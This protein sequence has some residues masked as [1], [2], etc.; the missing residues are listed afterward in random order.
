MLEM[1]NSAPESEYYSDS[2]QESQNTDNQRGVQGAELS[3]FTVPSTL[4]VCFS[5]RCP[6]AHI[7]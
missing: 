2:F 1:H 7:T 6:S 5:V 4:P 3:T